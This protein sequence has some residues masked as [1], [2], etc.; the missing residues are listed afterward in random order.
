MKITTKKDEYLG[1][2]IVS[3]TGLRKMANA[4]QKKNGTKGDV[5]T[6]CFVEKWKENG[7]IKRTIGIKVK[8]EKDE[9]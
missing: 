6:E 3:A 4:L 1:K 9:N 7:K 2:L 5:L 8:G